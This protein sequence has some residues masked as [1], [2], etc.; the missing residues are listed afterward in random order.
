MIGFFFLFV[1][2]PWDFINQ[3]HDKDSEFRLISHIINTELLSI[4][5]GLHTLTLV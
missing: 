2:S 5:L 3:F 4:G 1:V